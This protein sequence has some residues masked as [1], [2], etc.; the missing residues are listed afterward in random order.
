MGKKTS[1]WML[2][3]VAGGTVEQGPLAPWLSGRRGILGTLG[4][5]EKKRKIETRRCKRAPLQAL[6]PLRRAREGRG[7]ARALIRPSGRLAGVI[8]E[9][10][11]KRCWSQLGRTVRGALVQL[12]A[13]MFT[14]EKALR[15]A[16]G[17]R[18]LRA[19][20][21]SA[22]TALG[23]RPGHLGLASLGEAPPPLPKECPQ[24]ACRSRLSPSVGP[25]QSGR[26]VAPR[27][28]PHDGRS[29]A[30]PWQG[31]DYPWQSFG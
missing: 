14:A 8:V 19:A 17:A 12:G 4:T 22:P 3:C 28:N 21:Y 13:F 23:Q 11:G 31:K 1:E 7:N 16:S 5:P 29:P 18:Q 26:T 27:V 24:E 2:A 30:Q 15:R 10:H 20:P 9:R 25:G 6:Q